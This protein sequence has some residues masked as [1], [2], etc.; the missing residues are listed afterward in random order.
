MSPS[1]TVW[2]IYMFI[3]VFLTQTMTQR[4]DLYSLVNANQENICFG[5]VTGS[6]SEKNIEYPQ[7]YSFNV[8][9]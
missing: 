9:Y 5:L 6:D 2:L 8:L 4:K 3:Q 1:E 7:T